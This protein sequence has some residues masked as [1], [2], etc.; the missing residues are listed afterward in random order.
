MFFLIFFFVFFALSAYPY[1][2]LFFL[3]RGRN[4]ARALIGLWFLLMIASWFLLHRSDSPHLIPLQRLAGVIRYVWLAWLFW[5]LFL[6]IGTDLWNLAVRLIARFR[7]E[8]ARGV[9]S[10]GRQLAI[11]GVVLLLLTVWGLIESRMIRVVEV[12]HETSHMPSG[13][14]PLRIVLLADLHLGLINRADFVDRVAAIV[15]GLQPDVIVSAGD[16]VDAN[17]V[18]MPGAAAAL[19]KMQAPLGKFAV[20]GNHEWYIDVED[21]IA[22]TRE[23]GFTLL[24]EETATLLPGVIIAGVDDPAGGGRAL[25]D[26]SRTLPSADARPAVVLL[27]HQPLLEQASLG[28]FDLQ[29]SGHAHGGQIFPFGLFVAMR[30]P[31]FSGLYPLLD[32]TAI[33]TTPG[34]GTWG[35]PLRVGARPE[36]TLITL[37][38]KS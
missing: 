32:G 7:P 16:L 27:K 11:C 36:I 13:A 12:R 8:A 4:L 24:R 28:R 31:Y 38:P 9:L 33:Y 6:G 37:A 25:T 2:K 21:S 22:F 30:Y 26:E 35:P 34:T 1:S 29:L 18:L 19:A 23:G 3:L 17:P 15:E 5:F 10:R 14:K 20:L